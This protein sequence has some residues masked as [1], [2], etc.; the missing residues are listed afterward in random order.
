MNFDS[1]AF[2][3]DGTLYPNYALNLRLIPF[4]LKD[5]RFLRALGSAREIIRCGQPGEG[6]DFYTAQA[7]LMAGILG[8]DAGIIR[9]KVDT[10]IYRGWELH[11]KKIRLFSGVLETLSAFR[12]AGLKLGLLS[13]FPP[14]NKLEYLGIASC[15]D[16][17]LC[18][19]QVGRLKPDSLPFVELAGALDS[20]PHRILFVGN[21]FRYDI[22]GAKKAGMKAAL[23]KRSILST[24]ASAGG[25]GFG[26]KNKNNA[27]QADFVFSGYRQLCNYVLN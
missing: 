6:G 15:W 9:E 22:A 24:G 14:H 2:D 10:Q 26:A 8:V 7:A 5:W 19:E 27:L 25:T 12:A 16:A 4:V 11:F 1:V 20:E 18:S 3:L 13:D 23:I 21:S 17:A